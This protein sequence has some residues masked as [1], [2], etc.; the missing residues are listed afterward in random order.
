MSAR[1]LS[2]NTFFSEA[3]AW[4]QWPGIF[5]MDYL[6]PNTYKSALLQ[7]V[8]IYIQE[9]NKSQLRGFVSL[10]MLVVVMCSFIFFLFFCQIFLP[11]SSRN[12]PQFHFQSGFQDEKVIN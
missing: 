1:F 4:F 2:P 11:D 9:K 10:H 8:N 6:N 7:V 5:L 12:M 3:E